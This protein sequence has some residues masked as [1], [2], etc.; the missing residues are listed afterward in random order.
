M[1]NNNIK[2]AIILKTEELIK[3]YRLRAGGWCSYKDCTTTYKDDE[4]RILK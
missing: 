4:L 3:V 2:E 1:E